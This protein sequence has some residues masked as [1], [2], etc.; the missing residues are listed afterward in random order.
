MRFRRMSIVMASL[1][2]ALVAGCVT[3]D[4]S[5]E[6]D[7]LAIVSINDQAY[8]LPTTFQLA[9]GEYDLSFRVVG[10]TDRDYLLK[11]EPTHVAH[12]VTMYIRAK[13]SEPMLI[14]A[15]VEQSVVNV[16][17]DVD[18]DG[19]WKVGGVELRRK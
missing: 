11:I 5:P 8:S 6:T 19:G 14:I 13:D 4:D 2:L 9:P 1:A 16:G 10:Q 12:R 17:L 3:T 15:P 18:D 7:P